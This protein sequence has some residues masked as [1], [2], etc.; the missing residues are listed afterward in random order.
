MSLLG[1]EYTRASGRRPGFSQLPFPATGAVFQPEHTGD[2]FGVA[3]LA[4]SRHLY[5]GGEREET[6][7]DELIFFRL[8]LAALQSVSEVDGHALIEKT[9]TDIEEQRLAP[10]LRGVTGLL[11]QFTL[12]AGKRIFFPVETTSG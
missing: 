2:R 6:L 8:R 3:D 5:C 4:A 9:W 1:D 12:G 11:E 10:M 7:G